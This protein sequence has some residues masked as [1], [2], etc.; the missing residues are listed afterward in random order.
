MVDRDLIDATCATQPWFLSPFFED[1]LATKDLSDE[2]E[3]TVRGFARDGFV[4]L[5]N[6]FPEELVDRV[7]D[8]CREMFDPEFVLPDDLDSS[9]VRVQ[10][11]WQVM[12]AVRELACYEKVLDILNL[13]YGRECIPFQ[14]LNFHR[15]TQQAVHSDDIHFSSMPQGFMAGIWVPLEDID[16]R[17]GP[18]KYYPGSHRMPPIDMQ[19]LRMVVDGEF[20][21]NYARYE[22]YVMALMEE[23]GLE[24]KTLEV[25][26]GQSLIWSSNLVHGGDRILD[27]SRTRFSQV[28]HYYFRD[29][30]YWTPMYS[31]KRIGEYSLREIQDIRTEESTWGS[32]NGVEFDSQQLGPH[33]F[34]LTRR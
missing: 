25:A 2:A 14:T 19:D 24:S 17:N 30:L 10:D 5:E 31:N 15:G 8:G 1:I 32:Y 11:A 28:T 4:I 9:P 27:P 13:L 6:V 16:S 26:K 7:V 20:D 3:Q 18:L 12:P 29:C 22:T 34:T 21:P 23:R 33:R